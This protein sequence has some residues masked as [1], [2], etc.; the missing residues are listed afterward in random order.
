MEKVIR[1]IMAFLVGT[2]LPIQAAMNNKL[3]KSGGSPVHA[4]MISFG[5][6]ALAL[7]VYNQLC[8]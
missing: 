4:S 1:T 6:G 8:N 2:F 7:M 5:I 3:A